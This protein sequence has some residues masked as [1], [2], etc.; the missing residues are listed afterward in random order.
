FGE[1]TVKTEE[2]FRNRVREKLL[3]ALEDE[4]KNKMRKDIVEAHINKLKIKLPDAFLKRWIIENS[5]KEIAPEKLEEEYERYAEGL[6]WQ[7]FET[8]VIAENGLQ[9]EKEEV[10]AYTKSLIAQQMKQYGQEEIKDEQLTQTAEQLLQKEEESQNIIN[11][12]YDKKLIELY[13]NTCTFKHKTVSYDDFINLATQKSKKFKLFDNISNII[14]P[15]NA[16]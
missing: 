9:L 2:E 1:N 7:L 10:M 11:R 13:K 3:I 15:K 4:S 6:K 5:K 8:K 14:N 16:R 12:L